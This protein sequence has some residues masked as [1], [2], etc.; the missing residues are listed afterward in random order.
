[1]RMISRIQK[2][3]ARTALV[4]PVMMAL[5]AMPGFGLDT[6]VTA[7]AQNQDE[8]RRAENHYLFAEFDQA[9]ILLAHIIENPKDVAPERLRDAIVLQARCQVGLGNL[10]RAEDSFCD[11]LA[12]DPEW[13]PDPIFFPRT[14][15]EVFES[16]LATCPPPVAEEPDAVLMPAS[17]TDKPWYMKPVVWAGAAAAVV[18][19]VVL[20][21]GGDDDPDPG[22]QNLPA[23]PP[24]PPVPSR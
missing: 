2:S 13:R 10:L 22:T 15:I 19:A 9:L 7:L 16:A 1:M 21:G 8:L 3:N 12:L 4:L 11:V 23:P 18:L 17:S 20:A 14:E 6:V 5:L 24:P